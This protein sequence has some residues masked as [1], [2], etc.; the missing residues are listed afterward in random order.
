MI[1]PLDNTAA[2]LAN[3]RIIYG[4]KMATK[5]E[6]V[7]EQFY[8]AVSLSELKQSG[9]KRVILENG[10]VIAVFYVKD[11]VYALDHFCYR[12]CIVT[13]LV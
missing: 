11:E 5:G 13:C 7:Q 1:S 6:G 9:R 4:F 3:V 10:R 12:E 8:F 2:D